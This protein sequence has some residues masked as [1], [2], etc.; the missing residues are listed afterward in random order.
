[1]VRPLWAA[2]IKL[3]SVPLLFCCDNL[4][5][6]FPFV[7]PPSSS[8]RLQNGL[9]D[10]KPNEENGNTNLLKAKLA[11]IVQPNMPNLESV[12]LDTFYEKN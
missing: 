12:H 3:C 5:L 8:R 7:Y 4:H 6:L 2:V 9:T 11:E 10:K 1:M